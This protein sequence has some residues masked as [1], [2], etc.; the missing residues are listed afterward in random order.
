VDKLRMCSAKIFAETLI[1]SGKNSIISKSDI[2]DAYKLVPNPKTLWDYYGFSCLGKTFF[3]TT[4]VFGSAAAPASFDPL[5]ET[6]VNITCTTA[7]IPRKW[8]KRQHENVPVVSP[9]RFKV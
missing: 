2:Q 4:T 8:V 1:K 3:D 5:P 6:V 7:K 9:S